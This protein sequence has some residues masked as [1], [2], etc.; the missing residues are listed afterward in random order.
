MSEARQRRYL[1][2][3]ATSGYEAGSI[4]PFHRHMLPWL[5]AR[6]GVPKDALVVDIGA[7]SGHTTIPLH[8][9]GWRNLTA[10][11]ADDFNFGLFARDY[12]MRTLRCDVARDRIDV[13]DGAAGVVLC[14][15]LIEH[16]E[17]PTNLL[18]E[19]VRI[20]RP[21]GRAFIATPDWSKA[22]R[23][24]FDDPTH[25]HPYSKVALARLCRMHGLEAELHS[26]NARYGLGR[27]Q[28][29]RF[30]PRL[31]MIGGEML[32]IARKRTG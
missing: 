30:W 14:F 6:H 19:V 17:D 15:H 24:F 3:M 31:G 5:L 1:S 21:D 16:I 32:A 28:A 26:W 18:S 2:E 27:L 20:L 7:G 4:G 12:G 23:S 29:Y 10:V 13:A 8:G 25:R 22:W 9:A 11:D